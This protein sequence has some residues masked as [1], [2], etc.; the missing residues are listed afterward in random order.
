M[1][2]NTE[3]IEALRVQKGLP[4]YKI[5]EL[6]GYKTKAAYQHK[7]KGRRKFTVDDLIKIS[8]IFKIDLKE[9][10]TK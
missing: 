6:I 4:M 3:L 10:I 8:L 2:I 5:S 1:N 9:L 7:I